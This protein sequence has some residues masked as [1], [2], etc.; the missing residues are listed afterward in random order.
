[1]IRSYIYS[2][3]MLVLLVWACSDSPTSVS[4]TGRIVLEVSYGKS[5]SAKL[6]E[7]Q[8]I[9]RV[10]SMV[11]TVL[12]NVV[13]VKRQS[14]QRE[15]NR[16][17]GE[18]SVEAGSYQVKLEAY[19]GAVVK[20]RGV[21]NV[22]VRA[23]EISQASIVLKIEN[24]DPVANAGR[25]TTV[26]TGTT[27]QLDG[28]GSTDADGDQLEYRWTVLSGEIT[29]SDS[30]SES[31]SFTLSAA[32]TYR[33]SLVVNDGFADS[34]PDEVEVTVKP[35]NNPPVADAGG[36]TTVNERGMVTLDGSKSSD[37]DGDRLTYSWS[38]VSGLTVT[39]SD[40]TA[41]MPT[42]VA[43]EVTKTEA[44]TFRLVV[45]D[46]EFASDPDFV[47]ITVSDVTV[48]NP[49]V[50]NAGRD[51]TVNEGGTVTL[52]GSDSSDADGDALRYSWNQVSGLTAP[53][54]DTTAQMPTFVAP[55]VTKT[56]VLTFRLVVS[57]EEF[58]SDPDFVNI[59]VSDVSVNNPPVANAGRD[60]TVNEGGTVTLD[61]S[62]SSD[63]DGD[64]LTYSWNQV[65]GLTVP[66]SDTTAQMPTFV[67]PE[68][69]KTEVLTFRLVVSDEEFE[70]DPDFVN[71]TVSDVTVNNP[72]IADAGRDTT[73]N[74][75]GKV[76]LDGSKSSDPDG[77]ALT[78]S[79]SQVSGP[80]AP[81]S[82]TTAQVPTFVAPEV[83]KTEI[84]TF[85]L[86]VSDEEFE[87]QP[88]SVNVTVSDVS[89]NSPPV[90]DAGRDTTVN[91][92]GTVTL[93][94]SKSSDSDGDAFNI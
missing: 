46:E 6:A 19:V 28:S 32:G 54:S 38:Q 90:A 48:N 25:D 94:G 92:A 11:A 14:L 16:W 13:V 21:T 4:K 57:D 72:P 64:A 9:S 83:T 85:R 43:P 70:S 73:V 20:Y 8:A 80:E 93:D 79:W 76:T 59:T 51:T 82:D 63:P 26:T 23:G 42:F 74:E 27:V 10:D 15:I 84:L 86:V 1:M 7:V 3:V 67:A 81:L 22:N 91:E 52:D 40:T 78:Y 62:K 58:Q 33:I 47:N 37:P 24:L 65:S 53:L 39:L 34:S 71:I 44:L 30:S 88:D 45:S 50:A 68:V 49:P 60:T 75:G 17:R 36:D 18:I 56:E 89:V 31:P 29:L 77:D 87:S 35:Q 41:Q 5:P 12:R 61:G 2:V 55:E 69:T 66:L